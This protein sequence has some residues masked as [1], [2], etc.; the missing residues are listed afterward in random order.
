MRFILALG[1]AVLL[2]QPLRAQDQPGTITTHATARTR[3]PNTVADVAIGIDAHGQTLSAVQQSLADGSKTLLASLRDAGAERL[4]TEQVSVSPDTQSVRGAPNRIVGYSG[5]V[6]V[7][8]RVPADKLDQTLGNALASGGNALES[9]SLVPRETEVDAARQDL[10][11]QAVRTALAQAKTVAEAAGRRLG[12]VRQIQV[13]PGF[14]LPRPMPAFATARMM[15]AA[16]P[17]ATEPGDSEV[18]ATVSVTVGLIE[19]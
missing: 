9:T 19:P 6:R 15:D 12:P 5:R 10:A 16:A 8:F 4:V 14:G 7:R 13:D 18:A 11:A 3:L 1:L 2:A 17:I